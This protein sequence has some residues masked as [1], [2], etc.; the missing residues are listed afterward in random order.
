MVISSEDVFLNLTEVEVPSGSP[1]VLH[2]DLKIENQERY[3]IAWYFSDLPK[4]IILNDS[5]ALCVERIDKTAL[6]NTE[7][8]TWD[9]KMCHLPVNKVKKGWYFCSIDGDIPVLV[10][11]YTSN[12]THVVICKYG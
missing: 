5:H 11:N 10:Q 9:L 2:C 12:G 6:N 7:K 4:L 3:K 1:L 8:Q